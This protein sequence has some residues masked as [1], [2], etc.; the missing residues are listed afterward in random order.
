VH[1]CLGMA[2]CI[3]RA[4]HTRLLAPAAA[5][6]AAQQHAHLQQQQQHAGGLFGGGPALQSQAPLQHPAPAPG[7]LL[8]P[9][10]LTHDSVAALLAGGPLASEADKMVGRIVGVPALTP[11]LA[12]KAE[13]LDRFVCVRGTVTRVSSSRPI[14]R[15]LPF[16]CGRCGAETAVLLTAGKVQF[17][18]GCSDPTCVR[19]KAF[20]P[21]YEGAVAADMQRVQ[22]QEAPDSGE[23]GAVPRTVEAELCDDLC[24]AAN[25]GDTVTISGVLRAVETEVARGKGT[26]RGKSVFL[27]YIEATAV[28]NHRLA[29]G[30]ERVTPAEA[31]GRVH[32]A[33]GAGSGG[34]SGD[35]GLGGAGGTGGGGGAGGGGV[36]RPLPTAAELAASL[37]ASGGGGSS[38]ALGA[39]AAAAAAAAA[40]GGAGSMSMR[41]NLSPRHTQQG[42]GG[43]GAGAGGSSSSAAAAPTAGPVNTGALGYGGFTERD[44]RAIAMIRCHR[45]P[46]A[47]IVASMVPSIFGQETVKLGAWCCCCVST[48]GAAVGRAAS[49]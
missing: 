31:A 12:L 16:V 19:S 32:Y 46:S 44:L 10:L 41:A 45:D 38:G 21:L 20:Q 48:R 3:L 43:R 23:P 8:G 28:Q 9:H 42:G 30:D 25:P 22:L 5:S 29:A 33:G 14:V 24:D 7:A 35:D 40:G 36:G 26:A 39:S 1:G 27:L 6:F 17:P 47:L 37:H 34:V 13:K 18:G 15:R 4:I 49:G 11:L 2:L